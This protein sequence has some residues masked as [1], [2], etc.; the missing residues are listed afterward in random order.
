LKC[1]QGRMTGNFCPAHKWTQ[2]SV[3]SNGCFESFK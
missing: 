1:H 2:K 3:N